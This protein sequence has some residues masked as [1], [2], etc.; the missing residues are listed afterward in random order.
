[1]E[2]QIQ[3]WG[4]SLGLRIPIQFAKELQLHAGSTVN[5]ALEN[6][7]LV[8][9]APKYNLDRMLEEITPFNT[10]HQMLEDNQQLGREEW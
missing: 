1:M 6:G 5:I 9:E 4:N 3:K 7:K 2:I 8:I 10:H